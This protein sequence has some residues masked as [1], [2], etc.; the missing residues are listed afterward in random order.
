[1]DTTT[2]GTETGTDN[3][4]RLLRRCPH[5]R[6]LAG[7]AAGL[8]DYLDVDPTVVR[9]GLVLLALVGGIA[10]PLYIAAWLLIPDEEAEQS[11]AEELFR[12]WKG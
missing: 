12:R 2:T 6:M 3:R 4:P 11:I 1:M 10:V 7:V 9:V 8:A 5:E